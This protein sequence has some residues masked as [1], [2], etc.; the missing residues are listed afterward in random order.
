MHLR[1]ARGERLDE[2][3]VLVAGSV[4]PRHV[5]EEQSLDVARREPVELAARPVG[6]DVAQPADLGI[7]PRDE[8][9][10]QDD[11]TVGRRAGSPPVTRIAVTTVTSTRNSFRRRS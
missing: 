1:A 9:R 2:L 11:T 5:V 6:D 8:R 3:V 10:A 7:D 4:G